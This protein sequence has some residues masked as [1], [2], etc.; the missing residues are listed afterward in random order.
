MPWYRQKELRGFCGMMFSLVFNLLSVLIHLFAISMLPIFAYSFFA[1]CNYSP[2]RHLMLILFA[3]SPFN[4]E[5]F[6]LFAIW[7]LKLFAI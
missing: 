5:I 1:C 4:G 3:C 6:R 2:I 7:I